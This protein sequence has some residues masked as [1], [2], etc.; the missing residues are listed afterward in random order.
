MRRRELLILGSTAIALPLAAAPAQQ[1]AMPV[2]GYVHFGSANLAPTPAV[3]LQGLSET[4][5]V[6][7]Q[8]VTIEYRWAEGHYDRIPDWP[9][10]SSTARWI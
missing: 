2:I 3:F 1:K 4:G 8:N 6:P 10:T 7:G 5:Y 9:P